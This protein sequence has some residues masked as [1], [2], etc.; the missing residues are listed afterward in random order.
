[1][2]FYRYLREATAPPPGCVIYVSRFERFE[3]Y[4]FIDV[5]LS[6]SSLV[7]R[8]ANCKYYSIFI[9]DSMRNSTVF[10]TRLDPVCIPPFPLAFDFINPLP[11]TRLGGATKLHSDMGVLTV[12]PPSAVPG[13]VCLHPRA[14]H[15]LYPEWE[16]CRYVFD[17][18]FSDFF[19]C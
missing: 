19:I 18:F 2:R 10:F 6:R 13:L 1:M 7:T 17:R 16:A 14:T 8:V 5:Q 11:R 4:D 9:R 15:W 3:F 12:S